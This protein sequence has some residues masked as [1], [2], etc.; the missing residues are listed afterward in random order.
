MKQVIYWLQNITAESTGH[1]GAPS[2]ISTKIPIVKL[3]VRYG[4]SFRDG[5]DVTMNEKT[6]FKTSSRNQN[7]CYS[8]FKMRVECSIDQG[9]QG[10]CA[11]EEGI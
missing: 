2:N 3:L 9:D 6:L 8:C 10:Q 1:Y 11:S 4:I 7:S 5:T